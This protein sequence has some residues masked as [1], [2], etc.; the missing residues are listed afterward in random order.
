MAAIF[1]TPE[2]F[3][4]VVTFP[5]GAAIAATLVV[6][7]HGSVTGFTFGA[8]LAVPGT[9]GLCR[10]AAMLIRAACRAVFTRTMLSGA[11]ILAALIRSA[12]FATMRV[13]RGG[14]ILAA[15]NSEYGFA[16]HMA[17]GRARLIGTPIARMCRAIVRPIAVR[18]VIVRTGFRAILLGIVR[19]R[20]GLRHHDR[21]AARHHGA[22]R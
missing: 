6:T 8:G 2:E 19:R 9:P 22:V 20:D 4:R 10:T 18:P 15:G 1:V 16:A 7:L 5:C 11:F 3:R 12:P 14:P 21:Y 13:G 17:V